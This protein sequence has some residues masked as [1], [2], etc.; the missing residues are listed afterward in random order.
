MREVFADALPGIVHAFVVNIQLFVIAEVLVLVLG[1]LIAVLRSLP[2][3]VFF[4]LRIL[5]TVYADVFRAIPGVLVIFLL[6]F[7]IP[8]LGLV[9]PKTDKLSS[10][11]R[12]RSPSSTRPTSPRSIAPA[13]SRSTRARTRRRARS[14]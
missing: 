9:D 13:S 5:A 10:R 7:G 12:R 2:G 11:R 6:G 3:P 8:A 14:G 1:L 4:P